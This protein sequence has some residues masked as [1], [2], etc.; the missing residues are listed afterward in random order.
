[1]GQPAPD[2]FDGPSEEREREQPGV[3]DKRDRMRPESGK[4]L[5]HRPASESSGRGYKPRTAF[6]AI[7]MP[8]PSAC[9]PRGWPRVRPSRSDTGSQSSIPAASTRAS[10]Q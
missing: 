9:R 8:T 10:G 1:M 5:D 6:A 2:D 4:D 3:D 7:T